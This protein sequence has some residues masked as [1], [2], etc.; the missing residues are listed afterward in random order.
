MRRYKREQAAHTTPPPPHSSP[1]S[2]TSLSYNLSQVYEELGPEERHLTWI[3]MVDGGREM[4]MN[5]IRGFLPSRIAQ[6]LVNLH[7]DRRSFFFSRHGQ[8]EY[9][10]LGKIGGDSDLT[11]HGEKYALANRSWTLGPHEGLRSQVWPRPGPEA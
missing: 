11:E 5:N 3:K 2:H 8:S 4:S 9:N 6:F 1:I 10:R 7:V